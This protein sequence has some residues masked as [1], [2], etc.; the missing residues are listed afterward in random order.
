MVITSWDYVLSELLI[1][2]PNF[3]SYKLKAFLDS[4]CGSDWRNCHW[5]G[6]NILVKG[7]NAIYDAI[8]LASWV[9][10]KILKGCNNNV[11]IVKVQHFLPHLFLKTSIVIAQFLSASFD[12]AEGLTIYDI[13]ELER[14]FIT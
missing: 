7:E 14:H 8:E 12:V 5:K 3:A 10:S 4:E 13:S 2:W 11:F 1:E 6:R 9:M